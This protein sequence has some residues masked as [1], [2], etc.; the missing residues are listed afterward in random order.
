MMNHRQVLRIGKYAFIEDKLG[1]AVLL[2]PHWQGCCWARRNSS[3][4]CGTKGKLLLAVGSARR[5]LPS[6]LL[7]SILNEVFLIFIS[8]PFDQGLSSKALLI[9]TQVFYI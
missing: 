7:D 4:C 8:G 5:A 3:P 9:M 2:S 6:G 1:R